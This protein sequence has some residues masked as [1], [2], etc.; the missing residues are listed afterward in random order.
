MNWKKLK[1][2]LRKSFRSNQIEYKTITANHVD[3]DNLDSLYD[4]FN[5]Y[6][7]KLKKSNDCLLKQLNNSEET[8][9]Y[10]NE[11]TNKNKASQLRS[12]INSKHV[13][14]KKTLIEHIHNCE[15]FFDSS[16]KL[17]TKFNGLNAKIPK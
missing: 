8:L 13:L 6:F 1:K 2:S 14:S 17:F 5:E 3:D 10:L 15:K 7:N 11:Y 12:Q 16:Q 4:I 9:N